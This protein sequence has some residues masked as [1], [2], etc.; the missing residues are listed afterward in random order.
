MVLQSIWE[1]PLPEKLPAIY[2]PLKG[3]VMD[4]SIVFL[5]FAI[6]ALCTTG[7]AAENNVSHHFVN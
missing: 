3:C 6:D 4:E 2:F 1:D 5:L 7:N